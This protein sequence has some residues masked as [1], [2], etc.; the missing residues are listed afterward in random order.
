MTIKNNIS[1]VTTIGAGGVG[2]I[3]LLPSS[4]MFAAIIM[5]KYVSAV[6]KSKASDID[7]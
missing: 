6:F 2:D 1:S 3:G 7:R 4:V 5:S